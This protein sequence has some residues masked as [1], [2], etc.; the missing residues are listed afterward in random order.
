MNPDEIV[1]EKVSETEV[2]ITKPVVDVVEDI[3]SKTDMLN[4]ITFLDGE[5]TSTKAIYDERIAPFQAEISELMDILAKA[6]AQGVKTDEEAAPD[7]VPEESTTE[8]VTQ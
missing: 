3:R 8:Q 7:P 1:V 4:R 2:K 6:D 5:I